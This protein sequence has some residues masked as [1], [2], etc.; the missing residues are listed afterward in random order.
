VLFYDLFRHDPKFIK[1]KA[2]N[3]LFHEGDLGDD[4]YVLI[5]GQANV[6]IN[7]VLIG[8]CSP[9]DI[10]GEMAVVDGTPR[11]CTVTAIKGCKFVVIDKE[12]FH[13]LLDET[14]G[15]ALEVIRILARRLKE[16]DFRVSNSFSSNATV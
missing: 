15:F 1:V 5:A 4:M 8:S 11:Y 16:C 13:F 14:P 10:V 2:G 12:R 6:F 9:G 3:V 7:D